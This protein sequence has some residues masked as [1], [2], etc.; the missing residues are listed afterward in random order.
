MPPAARAVGGCTL[1]DGRPFALS[2]RGRDGDLSRPVPHVGHVP[3]APEVEFGAARRQRLERR[4]VP[5]CCGDRRCW[6][7][8]VQVYRPQHVDSMRA[9]DLGLYA[10]GRADTI[11][12]LH[13]FVRRWEGARTVVEN[14][15]THS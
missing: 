2:W 12:D 4:P 3:A 10:I 9:A 7:S 15:T 14:T 6:L 11:A 8:R 5:D 13:D 1:V